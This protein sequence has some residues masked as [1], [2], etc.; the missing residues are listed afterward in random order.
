LRRAA[1]EAKSQAQA[2][3]RAEA[4]SAAADALRARIAAAQSLEEHAK[5]RFA[6]EDN[7]RAAAGEREQLRAS[8]PARGALRY[9]VAGAVLVA[10]VAVLAWPSREQ[11]R[12]GTA[13]GEPLKLKLDRSLA[14]YKP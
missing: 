5:A 4:E 8:L 7:A 1:I 3:R 11:A 6:A 2:N 12:P 10:V 14:S 9:V 13:A